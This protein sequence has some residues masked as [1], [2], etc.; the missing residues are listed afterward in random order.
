MKLKI[1]NFRWGVLMIGLC[2]GMLAY[3]TTTGLKMYYQVS[4][5]LE[6]ATGV[7]SERTEIREYFFNRVNQLPQLGEWKE[8]T[9]QSEIGTVGLAALYCKKMIEKDEAESTPSRRWTHQS[10]LFDRSVDEGLLP[11][12]ILDEVLKD[13]ALLFWQRELTREEHLELTAFVHDSAASFK[14]DPQAIQKT[15]LMLCSVYAGSFDFISN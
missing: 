6:A 15:L 14:N 7:A 11:A 1:K 2:V 10:V 3:A 8:L 12:S 13:Y 9:A 4:S 5:S